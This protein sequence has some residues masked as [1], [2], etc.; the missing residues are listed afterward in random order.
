MTIDR[1]SPSVS[2]SLLPERMLLHC[3]RCSR[4][5]PKQCWTKAQVRMKRSSNGSRDEC[6]ECH[7]RGP[8]DEDW[9]EVVTQKKSMDK[10]GYDNIDLKYEDFLVRVFC[11]M[12]WR[13]RKDWS[14]NGMLPI[15]VD[16]DNITWNDREK[17]DPTNEVYACVLRREAPNIKMKMGWSSEPNDET[18]GDCIEGLLAIAEE[19]PN[20]ERHTDGIVC[21]FLERT[22]VCMLEDLSH[23]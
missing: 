18:C 15:R 11:N 1:L 8:T 17:F 2:F 16:T 7:S 4:S 6:R 23:S 13:V 5:L 9:D 19:H 10:L 21:W 22:G 14:Y 20:L 3:S 12:P